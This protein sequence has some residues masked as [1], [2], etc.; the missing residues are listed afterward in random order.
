MNWSRRQL[1]QTGPFLM[2]GRRPVLGQGVAAGDVTATQALIWSRADGPSRM[3]VRWRERRAGASWT[4]VMG[5][6]CLEVTDFTGR[7]DI[8]GWGPGADIEYEVVFRDLGLG[9]ADSAAE[10]GSFRPAPARTGP[11]GRR[12]Q[13]QRGRRT[14]G[15]LDDRDRLYDTARRVTPD[16][17]GVDALVG[18][19]RE[20]GAGRFEVLVE[21]A[22]DFQVD[23]A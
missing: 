2:K 16:Q 20:Q 13:R 15:L 12:K 7:V 14:R 1:L 11:R 5:P 18:F 10:R 17:R 4:E 22:A 23:L 9:G 3:I 6:H 21:D 8:G 19:V